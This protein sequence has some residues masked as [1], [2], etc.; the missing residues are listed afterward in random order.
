MSLVFCFDLFY[1]VLIQVFFIHSKKLGLLFVKK[2]Y[3]NKL[4]LKKLDQNAKASS[5]SMLYM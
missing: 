5:K 2:S 1:M 3:Q 4:K